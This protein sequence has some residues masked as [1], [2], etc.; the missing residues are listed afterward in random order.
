MPRHG[1][2]P[3]PISPIPPPIRQPIRHRRARQVL[4]HPRLPRRQLSPPKPQSARLPTS[5]DRLHPL[6]NPHRQPRQDLHRRPTRDPQ[7][8]GQR[9]RHRG[10]NLGCL[11]PNNPR[12]VRRL[13][14]PVHAI[15]P[16]E[17]YPAPVQVRSSPPT[18]G[19]FQGSR[20]ACSQRD[21]SP[22]TLPRHCRPDNRA[23]AGCPW[24]G[25]AQG[26]ESYSSRRDRKSVV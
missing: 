15:A 12:K 5:L 7:R 1:P 18:A 6:Q 8:P 4:P 11:P 10:P 16:R 3:S 22:R 9:R 26:D 23:L 21:Q 14:S 20:P 2:K 19:Q 25:R 24:S 13:T 17:R